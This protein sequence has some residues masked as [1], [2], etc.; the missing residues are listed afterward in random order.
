MKKE[1]RTYEKAMAEVQT[2]IKQIENKE[3]NMDTLAVKIKEA[4]EHLDYCKQQ[5][6]KVETEINHILSNQIETKE[7]E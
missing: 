2:L 1:E 5:L 6:F 7:N 3:I 4:S